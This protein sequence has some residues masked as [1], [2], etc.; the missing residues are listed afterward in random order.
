MKPVFFDTPGPI[1][2]RATRTFGLSAKEGD[3]PIGF[4]GTGLKYAIAILVR[5]R[6]NLTI[7]SEGQT[8]HFDVK[9]NEFRGNDYLAITCN[10]EEM[11]FTT[12]LGAKW[13]MW[14]AFRE[15]YCNTKDEGGITHDEISR[16]LTQGWSR[17]S[18]VNPGFYS[19][20]VNRSEYFIENE[21]PLAAH[22]RV[23]I[24]KGS[25]A[26]AFY[27]GIR[28][29]T[30]QYPAMNRYNFIG[31]M[32]LT[33]D[34]TMVSPWV[35]NRRVPSVI[36]R[37][38]DRN[39]IRKFVLAQQGTMEQSFSFDISQEEVSQE[40]MEVMKP[41]MRDKTGRV[42]RSAQELY[43]H[44]TKKPGEHDYEEIDLTELQQLQYNKALKVCGDLGYDVGDHEV[45]F[46]KHLGHGILGCVEEGKIF[47]A[48]ESFEQ[49][50]KM[51]TG[52]VMEEIIHIEHDV[53]DCSRGMQNLLINKIMSMYEIQ[54]GE[55]L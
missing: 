15:L 3:N 4:F 7:E 53:R 55:P 34:R 8:Y 24:Y 11:P 45:L 54:K 16:P 41:L 18:V 42:N 33:E 14:M 37:C 6:A 43:R 40:F 25:S 52:T 28:A 29:H 51:L 9:N 26:Y 35:L 17:I 13:E 5:N 30:H 19:S 47:I 46:V 49:G 10:G 48:L 50:T 27:K 22:G 39:L 32:D 1:D 36:A 31:N 21:W 38:N 23:E 44:L 20:Y 12:H 2:M